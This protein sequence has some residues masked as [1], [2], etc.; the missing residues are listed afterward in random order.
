V[1]SVTSVLPLPKY[2]QI[3]LVLR[4]LHEGRFAGGMPGEIALMHEFGV[5]RVTVPKAL[6]QLAA[7]RLI[8]GTPR[9]GTVPLPTRTPAC[10]SVAPR[11]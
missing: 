4:E 7:E 3:Y 2:H 10:W 5:A 9:R 11:R 8:R 6:E 1:R